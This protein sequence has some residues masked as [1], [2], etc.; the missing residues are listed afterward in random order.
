MAPWAAAQQNCTDGIVETNKTMLRLGTIFAR[1]AITP[2]DVAILYSKSSSF[3]AL[4]R[5]RDSRDN[6]QWEKLAQIYLA[7][8]MTQYPATVVLDEDA[9]DGTLAANHKA[10]VLT[11]IHYL[12]P[13]VVAGLEGFASAGGLVLLTDD[14][15]VK[16]AG[17]VKL[18]RANSSHFAEANR[19]TAKIADAKQ[20]DAEKARLIALISVAKAVQPVAAALKAALVQKGIKPAFDCDAP[21]VTAA[22]ARPAAKSTISSRSTSLPAPTRRCRSRPQRPT[23]RC[24]PKAERSTTQYTA[25]LSPR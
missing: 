21:G 17:A 25:G 6:E 13:A 11:G 3:Y 23:S 20:R 12:D 10:V 15:T 22:H 1:P 8:R 4:A 19:Q 24:P 14:C 2:A 5:D 9:I 7:T 16:V 18:G